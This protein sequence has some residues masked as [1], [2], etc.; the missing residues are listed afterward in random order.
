MSTIQAILTVG[1]VVGFPLSLLTMP[2]GLADWLTES[3]N[4]IGIAPAF[5]FILV[6]FVLFLFM[7][8]TRQPIPV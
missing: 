3:D 4:Q 5:I 6:L 7:M 2:E 1:F 8:F